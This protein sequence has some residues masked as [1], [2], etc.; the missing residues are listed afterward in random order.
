MQGFRVL[1][2]RGLGFWGYRVQVTVCL[3]GARSLRREPLLTLRSTACR[4]GGSPVT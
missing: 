2:F 4:V 3:P 1:G